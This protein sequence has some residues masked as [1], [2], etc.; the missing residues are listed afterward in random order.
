MPPFSPSAATQLTVV[1]DQ[2]NSQPAQS[3]NLL[4]GGHATQLEA[5]GGA[6][7]T[8][9]DPFPAASFPP[10]VRGKQKLAALFAA[11][12]AGPWHVVALQQT[13]HAGQAEPTQWCR[14]GPNRPLGRPIILG[15]RHISKPRGG[16]AVQGLSPL[17]R[18]KS[19]LFCFCG[20]LQG[21]RM[22]ISRGDVHPPTAK[23][24]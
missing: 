16:L 23:H 11:L 21:Y 2:L 13:H 22:D 20:G 12:Q 8:P 7:D 19:G 5:P 14:E 9:Q 24:R 17:V 3:H 18:Y 4:P 1:A 15:F 6:N 10:Q